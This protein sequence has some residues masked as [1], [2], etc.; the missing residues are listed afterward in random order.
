[1]ARSV[2]MPTYTP[3][4]H[5]AQLKADLRAKRLTQADLVKRLV[6][7]ESRTHTYVFEPSSYQRISQRVHRFLKGKGSIDTAARIADVLGYRTS[8]YVS[9]APTLR[10]ALR[11]RS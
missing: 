5:A 7:A 1:M 9:V 4:Y 2:R 10:R 6:A 11:G 3:L 8:R